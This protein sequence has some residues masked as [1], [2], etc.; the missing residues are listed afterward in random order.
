MLLQFA[1]LAALGAACAG[2]SAPPINTALAAENPAN[3]DAASV[4]FVRPVNVLAQGA[5]PQTSLPPAAMHAAGGSMPGIDMSGGMAGMGQGPMPGNSHA[6]GEDAAMPG[7]QMAKA[8]PADAGQASAIG[9]VKSVNSVKHSLK[10][11]HQP[12]KALGWPSMT[13]EFTV[14][15]S[16]RLS[17]IKPGDR[18]QFMLGRSD[19]AGNRQVLELKPLPGSSHSQASMPGMNHSS[20]PAMKMPGD[21]Q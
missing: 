15:P 14:A 8:T 5:A 3:P 9:T 21:P 17:A 18:I 16:V 20:M 2:C 6:H 4:P 10:L 7:M 19:A 11:V 1:L 12:I 13:M